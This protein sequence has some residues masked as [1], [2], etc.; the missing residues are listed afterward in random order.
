VRNYILA[1]PVAKQVP[2][3][4]TTPIGV[5]FTSTDTQAAIEEV[6]VLASNAS[7]GATLC[8]FDGSASSGRWL[9]FFSNNPSNNNPFVVAEPSELVALS[10][11]T[12]AASATGTV[13]IYNNGSPITTISLAAAKTAR[14]KNL[15]LGL[16]DLDQLSV[17]VT[18]GNITR[19]TVAVFIRTLP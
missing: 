6:Y 10:L 12:S 7:R 15:A 14:V 11:S 16:T 8:G 4:N 19:P 1:T 17:Q 18:S 3:D 9:E 13:T 5:N 2:F